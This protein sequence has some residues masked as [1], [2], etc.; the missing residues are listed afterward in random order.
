LVLSEGAD[1]NAGSEFLEVQGARAILRRMVFPVLVK[2][3]CHR[4]LVRPCLHWQQAASGTH[5]AKL[6]RTV[7]PVSEYARREP[8]SKPGWMNQ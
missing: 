5:F 2:F 8:R 7:F 3:G 1:G 4:R 6:T